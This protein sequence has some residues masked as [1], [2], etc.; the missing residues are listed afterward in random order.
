ML[1]LYASPGSKIYREP[2]LNSWGSPSSSIEE[3]NVELYFRPKSEIVSSINGKDEV[4]KGSIYTDLEIK[5]S[6]SIEIG[7]KKYTPILITQLVGLEEFGW[8]VD[9]I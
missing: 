9:V 4:S 6:D 7:G 3:I 5:Y 2:Q 1:E 8:K